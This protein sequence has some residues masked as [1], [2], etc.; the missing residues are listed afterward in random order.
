MRERVIRIISPS[1][2]L[3]S[4]LDL[5]VYFVAGNAEYL[6]VFENVHF[7][8]KG[9]PPAAEVELLGYLI[10]NKRNNLAEKP[11]SDQDQDITTIH[12]AIDD[13]LF[14]AIAS[15][16][17]NLSLEDPTDILWL[18]MASASR[19]NEEPVET[20]INGHLAARTEIIYKG[21]IILMIV[22]IEGNTGMFVTATYPTEKNMNIDLFWMR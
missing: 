22:I 2:F 1:A 9:T 6:R 4:K 14:D 5:P 15:G 21:N 8:L 13:E 16:D 7:E 10:K 18:I 3:N 17:I 19:I 11:E 12:L 20:V